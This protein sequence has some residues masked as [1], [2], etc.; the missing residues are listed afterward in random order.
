MIC[1][2]VALIYAIKKNCPIVNQQH[3][4]NAHLLTIVAVTNSSRNNY[5]FLTG[6]NYNN[7][8]L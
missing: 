3:S 5:E 6:D 1:K 8:S 7:V 2:V 4:K